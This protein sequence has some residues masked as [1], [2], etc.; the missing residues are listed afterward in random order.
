MMFNPSHF[1]RKSQ[2]CYNASSKKSI[3]SFGEYVHLW[4]EWLGSE[5]AERSQSSEAR[6]FSAERKC[7][8]NAGLAS[9]CG[10]K[11][12]FS[13]YLLQ[14]LHCTD[15]VHIGRNRGSPVCSIDEITP[16]NPKAGL[17]GHWSWTTLK[18]FLCPLAALSVPYTLYNSL[19]ILQVVSA[20]RSKKYFCQF[21]G[22]KRGREREGERERERERERKKERER[23][24]EKE[25]KGRGQGRKN[26]NQARVVLHSNLTCFIIR[27]HNVHQCSAKVGQLTSAL[28][29][30]LWAK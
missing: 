10:I 23:E 12:A 11:L 13:I 22:W 5:K 30:L 21:R 24:R 8:G 9:W 20:G 25:T 4:A 27:K 26:H 6:N 3:F 28:L 7:P 29:Y 14:C 15:E 2:S 16:E 18:K 19:W 1:F 17:S